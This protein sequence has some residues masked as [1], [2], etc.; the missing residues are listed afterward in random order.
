VMGDAFSTNK[1]NNMKHDT[2]LH[3]DGFQLR[4]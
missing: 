3:D 1:N 2:L 4:M